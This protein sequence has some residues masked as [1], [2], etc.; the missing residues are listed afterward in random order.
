MADNLEIIQP[1]DSVKININQDWEVQS[2]CNKLN[3]SEKVLRD[4]VDAVGVMVDNV[5]EYLK[6]DIIN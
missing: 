2:W 6:Q 1:E 4:A 3:V 5:K